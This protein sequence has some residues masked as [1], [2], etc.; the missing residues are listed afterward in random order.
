MADEPFYSPN[1]KAPARRSQG[2]VGELLWEIRVNHV[3]W[4]A[5]LF[6][7]QEYGFD[8]RLFRDTEFFA[9]RRL[10]NREAAIA[11]ANE[12]RGDIEKGWAE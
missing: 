11:W 1:H 5:E 10:G 6:D 3:Q 4:R 12:Q 8:T 9:S 2:V 7:E